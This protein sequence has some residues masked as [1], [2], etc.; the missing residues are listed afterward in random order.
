MDNN[1]E[2]ALDNFFQRLGH[3]P[4]PWF[5]T[6][7]YDVRPED[8]APIAQ[9]Y[10]TQFLKEE[11][12]KA[13]ALLISESPA[14]LRTLC[15]TYLWMLTNLTYGTPTATFRIKAQEILAGLVG[16][17]S[18]ATGIDQQQVQE[19]FEQYARWIETADIDLSPDFIKQG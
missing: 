3:T 9:A 4:G 14:M 11:T 8:K 6:E 17:I 7:D 10:W 16:Q 2:K 12:V 13:N 1:I 19:T 15:R 18:E 5:F